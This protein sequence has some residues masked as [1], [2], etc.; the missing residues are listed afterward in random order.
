MK[1]SCLILSLLFLYVIDFNA[2]TVSDSLYNVKVYPV[3]NGKFILIG[4]EKPG[5]YRKST[6]RLYD[7]N[8]ILQKE[9]NQKNIRS[10][11]IYLDENLPEEYRIIDRY[12]WNKGKVKL[13]DKNLN[14]KSSVFFK[15]DDHKDWMIKTDEPNNYPLKS[16]EEIFGLDPIYHSG[17]YCFY[18]DKSEGKIF[19][20]KYDYKNI[21]P[22][23]LPYKELN[24]KIDGKDRLLTYKFK[25]SSSGKVIFNWTTE[26]DAESQLNFC[27]IDLSNSDSLN[28]HS[29][30][31]TDTEKKLFVSDFDFNEKENLFLVS[32]GY[33]DRRGNLPM[34]GSKG[35]NGYFYMNHPGFG[36]KENQKINVFIPNSAED[37]EKIIGYKTVSTEFSP[38]KFNL[39]F[40]K[41]EVRENV[42]NSGD[43]RGSF[44]KIFPMKMIS[45]EISEKDGEESDFIV[46][47]FFPD[48]YKGNDYRIFNNR[49]KQTIPQIMYNGNARNEVFD[50]SIV[51]ADFDSKKI[52][53]KDR[54]YTYFMYQT[55]VEKFSFYDKMDKNNEI[56]FY[57]GYSIKFTRNDFGY[58]L[59]KLKY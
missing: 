50:P 3:E 20:T 9:V 47:D 26:S 27:M 1:K 39:L 44:L 17:S 16:N 29:S 52:F 42:V 56:Y 5:N 19:I 10:S 32:G 8:L 58:K 24:L 51:H 18:F 21:K 46:F 35:M 38:E 14:L 55:D 33:I 4:S 53:Y 34:D 6:I 2:Q 23:Y 48:Q 45:T 11:D 59:E 57:Q 25:S 41:F 40:E 15:R 37:S 12:R 13:F 54:N 36:K 30:F 49:S 43:L 28:T 31:Y 22:I 7:E